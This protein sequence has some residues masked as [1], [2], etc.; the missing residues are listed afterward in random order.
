M[1]PTVSAL[2]LQHHRHVAPLEPAGVELELDADR[3]ADEGEVVHLHALHREVHQRRLADPDGGHREAER[4]ELVLLA[5][6]QPG[7]QLGVVRA[8]REEDGAGELAAASGVG[9]LAAPGAP[10]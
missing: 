3:V 2:A 4:G 7:L 8:V 10:P 5:G 1:V 9:G 6:L